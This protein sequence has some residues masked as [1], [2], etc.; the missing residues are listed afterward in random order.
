MVQLDRAQAQLQALEYAISKRIAVS[1]FFL[2]SPP[3]SLPIG[4]MATLTPE[5]LEGPAADDARLLLR[6]LGP[7]TS[8]SGSSSVT[9]GAVEAELRV[10]E[11]RERFREHVSVFKKLAANLTPEVAPILATDGERV[12]PVV[13]LPS[14]KWN[15]QLELEER[16]L[17]GRRDLV[18]EP[19]SPV[20]KCDFNPLIGQTFGSSRMARSPDCCGP[21]RP[22]S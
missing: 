5:E 12:S 15:T 19:G 10:S 6:T 3:R 22:G 1:L 16:L 21:R 13:V 18:I 11:I 20:P 4:F 7:I 14:D 8:R 9:G 17:L 2:L